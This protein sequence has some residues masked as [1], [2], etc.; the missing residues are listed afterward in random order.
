M[1]NMI[2]IVYVLINVNMMINKLYGI[3]NKMEI[4]YVLILINV[5]IFYL[6]PYL[7]EYQKN[8]ININVY[9]YVEVKI[10]NLFGMIKD[11]IMMLIVHNMINVKEIM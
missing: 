4:T 10:N 11:I 9:K 2:T 1:L 3:I 8:K 7:K 6:K 5:K